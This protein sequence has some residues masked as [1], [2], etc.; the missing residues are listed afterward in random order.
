MRYLLGRHGPVGCSTKG[1]S[2]PELMMRSIFFSEFGGVFGASF[3]VDIRG[4]TMRIPFY[5]GSLMRGH[6]QQDA[7][8]FF[9]RRDA[10]WV[11][12]WTGV[13]YAVA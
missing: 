2:R 6:H 12:A 4:R 1:I 7:I 5:G 8:V 13:R 10:T 3:V 11:A 9:R